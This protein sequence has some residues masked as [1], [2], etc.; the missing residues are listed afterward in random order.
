MVICVDG[1]MY[2]GIFIV[3]V[4]GVYSKV[5]ELMCVVVLKVLV[6]LSNLV[7]EVDFFLILYCV[8]WI[9]FFMVLLIKVGDVGEIYGY[10]CI[11]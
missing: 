4:D 9:W 3:G 2:D 7:N 8:M 11:L 10:K 1:I 6:V 5:R